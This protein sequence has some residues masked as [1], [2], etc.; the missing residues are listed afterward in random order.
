[1]GW[2][3]SEDIPGLRCRPRRRYA[4]REVEGLTR[5]F[6]FVQRV[7]KRLLRAAR[8]SQCPGIL[9]QPS[10]R[11]TFAQI[12][13][14]HS[15][16][17][18]SQGIINLPTTSISQYNDLETIQIFCMS[19]NYKYTLNWRVDTQKSKSRAYTLTPIQAAILLTTYSSFF[20]VASHAPF[21]RQGIN[22][23]HDITNYL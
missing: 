17:I 13:C 14:Q 1:M 8:I 23:I 6:F 15:V 22:N 18:E 5:S 2:R 19:H 20:K 4:V 21:N 7:K 10:S 12:F 16:G 3:K 11:K 9:N